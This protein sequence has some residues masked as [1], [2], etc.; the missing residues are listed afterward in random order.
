MK[1]NIILG[2]ALFIVTMILSQTVEAQEIN[3][4]P[5]PQHMELKEGDFAFSPSTTIHAQKELLPIVK[6]F[7]DV[8]VAPLGTELKI[9]GDGTSAT[10]GD[11]VFGLVEGMAPEGY[12]LSVAKN[13]IVLT[14]STPAGIFRGLQTLRQLMPVEAYAQ[15]KQ[16]NTSWSIPCVEI[17][18]APSFA[19]RGFM[20]DS[21]RHFQSLSE[22][23]RLIDLIAQYK[24]NVFHWH[25]VDGHGWRMESKTYPKLT[26]VGAWRMQPDY[27]TKGKTERYGGFYTQEEIK[28]LVA[29][30]AERHITVVPEIEMPGHSAA[31]VASY[32]EL[33]GCKNVDKVGV[34]HFYTY[35][36]DAQR[37]PPGGADVFCAGKESTFEFIENILEETY[38]LFPSEYIHI[39]G[40]EVVKAQW[41]KCP[42]CQKRMNDEGL[43]NLEELQSYFIKRAEKILAKNG[44]KLIGWDEILEGGL[45]EKSAVM[46][47]RG[48]AGGV[49]AAKQGK[50]IVM[51]PEQSLYLDRSQSKSPL[52]PPHWPGYVPL[53]VVYNFNPIPQELRDQGKSHLVMGLQGNLWTIFTHT[54]D[55]NDLMT[56]PRLCAISELGWTR[57]SERSY[58]DFTKRLEVDKKRLSLQDVNYWVE[59][60][61]HNIASWSPETKIAVSPRFS[62]IK[63]DV[64][65]KIDGNGILHLAFNFQKGAHRVVIKS[66][67]LLKGA[68]L[69]AKDVHEGSAGSG[70][71]A[72]VYK[73]KIEDYSKSAE[74][75]LVAELSIDN[76]AP[77]GQKREAPRS[78]GNVV[79][80][81]VK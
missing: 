35:P 2:F 47:W 53:D 18:D 63:Y 72:N 10:T 16:A 22:L 46:S 45:P 71:I 3:L 8:L 38:E 64:S 6:Y 50:K 28:Q 65:D 4:I 60:V 19:W 21:S 24:L 57:E 74:Y 54:E 26:S 12:R 58:E 79:M 39:G 68:K 76:S 59:P 30:A 25:L 69:V 9:V 36:A 5:K 49:E 70:H 27:P 14:A 33:V 66:V 40:D 32:P 11:I 41:A 37:F 81:L 15:V 1:L 67:K 29:Y 23:L 61:T 56:F 44:R 20:I 7:V 75:T 31:A 51:S 48:I 55:L 77:K 34:H 78:Y 80:S 42:D 43:K 73:L 52:H 62:K 17:E 13:K